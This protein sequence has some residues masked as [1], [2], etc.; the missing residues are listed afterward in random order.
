M[1]PDIF[2]IF[3]CKVWWILED[4]AGVNFKFC[5]HGGGGGGSQTPP[6]PN[7]GPDRLGQEN[8]LRMVR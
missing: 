7:D 8:L 1:P 2:L 3:S 6:P 5:G 4:V